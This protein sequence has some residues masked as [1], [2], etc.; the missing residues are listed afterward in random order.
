MHR[1]ELPRLD[2]LRSFEAAARLASFTRAADE[3]ALTQSAVSRQV[4]LLEESVGAPLFIRRHRAIELTEAGRVLQRAVDDTLE[5]LRD[6]TARIR[7]M[8]QPRQVSVTTTPGF[9]SLWLIPRL[10]RFTAR[11]PEVD[12]RVSA[13][14]EVM[15]LARSGIDVAVRFM[16]VARG[17]GQ[18]LF[19]ETIVP[20]CAPALVRD[21]ARPLRQP[22]D[23]ARH[24]LLAVDS[25]EAD[26]LMADWAPWLVAMGQPDL[27]MRNTLRFSAYTEAV[28]AAMAGQGVV[29]GRLPLVTRLIAAGRLVA[30]FKAGASSRRGYFVDIA[31]RSEAQVVT[32]DLVAWLLEEAAA[33]GLREAA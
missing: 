27:R 26:S 11:H 13:T 30:P 33:G 14:L 20:V 5:R 22:A 29:I 1:S 3:L 12:V 8:A 32:R 25:H 4:Q 9:A 31:P 24:T 6:A 21:A 18:P 19:E 2:L 16:P 15:D 7:G 17:H 23:L 10:A 28:E